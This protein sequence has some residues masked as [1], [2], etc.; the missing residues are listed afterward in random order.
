VTAVLA[1]CGGGP[2]YTA[3]PE[4]ASP[5]APCSPAPGPA[6]AER[7]Q[8]GTVPDLTLP[9]FTGGE[10]VVLARL[11]R[12]TVISLW[13]SSCPPCREELPE[14]QRFADASPQVAVLGVVTGDRRSAAASLAADLGITFPSVDDPDRRLLQ[15]LGRIALPVTLFVD[16]AGVVRHEDVSGALT[17]ERLRT[18]ATRYLG[19]P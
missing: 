5:L 15:A 12:P 14:L 9:C 18:L 17:T 8:S 10:P 19:V 3:E 7:A 11:G 2:A 6:R 1:A 4:V 16:A 13:A